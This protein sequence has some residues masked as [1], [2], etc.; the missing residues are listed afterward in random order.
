[1]DPILKSYEPLVRALGATLGRD[2]E[3]V[4]H[5]LSH[6]RTS[7]VMIENAHVTGRKVGDG[8]RDLI[9]GVLRSEKFGKDAL[10]NYTTRLKDGR[11]LKST[12]VVIRDEK[13]QVIGALC[14]NFDLSRLLQTAALLD[15]MTTTFELA[16]PTDTE[17]EIDRK[18][19]MSIL[20]ELIDNAAT[21][22]GIPAAAM[23]RQSRLRLVDFLDEKGA[24]L[25]KGSVD[26]VGQAL[27]VSRFTV[28]NYI[29]ET[30][31]SRQNRRN[32]R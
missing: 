30:R 16:E 31:A 23:D 10:V 9:I 14:L 29:D 20:S 7:V 25:V 8:I 24:F 2:C 18:D 28:Y 4:L 27:G 22:I 21:E 15:E 19:V 17:V 32:E 3:V 13:E 26:L 5:D 6:P 1:M 12:T 11:R